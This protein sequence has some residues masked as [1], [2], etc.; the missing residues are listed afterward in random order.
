LAAR[1][2]VKAGFRLFGARYGGRPIILP[3]FSKWDGQ[4]DTPD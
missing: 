3:Q 4:P 1:V 2:P